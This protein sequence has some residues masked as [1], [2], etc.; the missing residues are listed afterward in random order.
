PGGGMGGEPGN[1]AG[2]NPYGMGMMGMGGMGMPPGGGM[3][4]TDDVKVVGSKERPLEVVCK[5][6][7]MRDVE[8]T[9]NNRLETILVQQLKNTG[10]FDY[11]QTKRRTLKDSEEQE[12]ANVKADKGDEGKPRLKTYMFGLNLVLREPIEL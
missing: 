9:A 7:D 12:L 5:A 1:P 8:V 10:L 11:E 4:G 3:G 6:I 2:G